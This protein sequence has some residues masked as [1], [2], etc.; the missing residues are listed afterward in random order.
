MRSGGLEKVG[1]K[2]I[3][4]IWIAVLLLAGLVI[5]LY[6]QREQAVFALDDF[7]FIVDDPNMRAPQVTLAAIRHML[8]GVNPEAANRPLPFISFLLDWNRGNGD[9]AVF[10]RTN[11]V[12]HA[13]NALLVFALARK[14]LLTAVRSPEGEASRVAFFAAAMWAAHPIHLNAVAY[15]CQR[16]TEMAALGVM[17]GLLCYLCG[18]T[19][20]A[21]SARYSL[22]ALALVCWLVACICKENAWIAPVFVVLLELGVVRN[23]A[24]TLLANRFEKLG[25][26]L[27]FGGGL[28]LALSVAIGVGPLADWLA[29]GYKGW[30]FT[31]EQR[32]LTQPGVLIFHLSQLLWP[33]PG[34][35]AIEH[36]IA[37]ATGLFNPATTLP[38]LLFIALWAA[39]GLWWLAKRGQR[40]YG[41]LLLFPLLALS[42]ESSLIP[43]D[44]VFEHR[45]YLPSVSIFL[46]VGLALF[47]LPGKA[48]WI[49]AV[50]LLAGLAFSQGASLR[51]WNSRLSIYEQAAAHAQTSVRAQY[52]YANA[53]RV[54]GR[55]EEALRH[56]QMAL[57]VPSPSVNRLDA[58]SVAS[59]Y[60][61]QGLALMAL[62]RNEEARRSLENVLRND[63][64]HLKA[65]A[66]LADLF[67]RLGD[68][69]LTRL[70]LEQVVRLDPANQRA[71]DLLLRLQG[72]HH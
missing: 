35:F 29:R 72:M 23:L 19:A 27:A 50:L 6:G 7:I 30:D 33:A 64:N 69:A 39:G 62:H 16:M 45:M 51:H 49:M 53:L 2:G 10:Y 67:A 54:A 48:G 41:A 18:R 8:A 13:L 22:L 60:F 56:Y 26:A 32:L 55:N 14:I 12:L 21:V 43:L 66:F 3:G 65:H 44:M 68:A 36:D 28:L 38:A 63:P 11:I 71:R 59:I 1:A 9:P 34:R 46:M 25:L 4:R 42:V 40:L 31:L 61:N 37:I 58:I 20:L 15:I 5:A 52:N 17:S 70:H 57:A 24:P 47:R